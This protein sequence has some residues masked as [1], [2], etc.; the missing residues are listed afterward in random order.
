[1]A[2]RDKDEHPWPSE[3]KPDKTEGAREVGSLSDQPPPNFPARPSIASPSSPAPPS[4]RRQPLPP[5]IP[6]HHPRQKPVS[7]AG[8]DNSLCL[9]KKKKMKAL[10]D[11]RNLDLI[12][13]AV[14]RSLFQYMVLMVFCGRKGAREGRQEMDGNEG[15]K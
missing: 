3:D 9:K 15:R 5:P 6:R 10:M 14:F 4:S 7:V 12:F 1:M 8:A 13:L 11:E 2:R